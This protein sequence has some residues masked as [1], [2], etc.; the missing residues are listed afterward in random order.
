[1]ADP[2]KIDRQTTTP[3]LLRLF[4][5]NGQFHRLEEFASPRLPPHLQI[6]TWQSCT[7]S[8]LTHL[9]LTALPS[10]L[11]AEYAGTRIAYRLI[12]PD[13]QGP[14]RPG[15]APRFIARDLGSVIVGAASV[16]AQ[17]KKLDN[18][19]EDEESSK[20]E[21]KAGG[22]IVKDALQQ[23]SGELN[24][25]L[26]DAR[27]VI[28]DYISAAILPPLADG[29]VAASPPPISGASARG[30]PPREPYGNRPGPRENGYGGRPGD[31]DRFGRGGRGGGRF[32]ERRG[33]G[34]PAGEWRRG[35]APP[36]PERD[37]YY[38]GGGGGG[39]GR[40]RGRW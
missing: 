37:S 12:F 22:D 20:D 34:F 39:R 40:G 11:P 27:F 6:Y 2:T 15:T 13:M 24:K 4:Y 10:L 29:S 26:Q 25:T 36:A 17:G 14:S 23:L 1:M 5:K 19:I 35:E 9:L 21:G 16:D 28:G 3:F 32:D 33:G 31:Y 8:E 30:P 38:R 18:D 7:L